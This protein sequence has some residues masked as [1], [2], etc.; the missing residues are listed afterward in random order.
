MS[1]ILVYIC[2]YKKAHSQH[3]ENTGN[4]WFIIFQILDQEEFAELVQGDA[5]EVES[6]EETDTIDIIDSIRF[7]LTNFVQTFS[8]LQEMEEKIKLIDQFLE[9][10]GLEA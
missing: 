7:H 5:T 4:V 6:R 8:E 2:K 10:L 9:T 1:R 3:L